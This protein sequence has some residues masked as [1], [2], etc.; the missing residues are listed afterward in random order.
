MHVLLF[1][2]LRFMVHYRYHRVETCVAYLW[3]HLKRPRGPF[4][5]A[6]KVKCFDVM[7]EHEEIRKKQAEVKSETT[8]FGM[9]Q[10]RL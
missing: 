7:W 2:S 10:L 1:S 5:F 4:L 8:M 3:A 9:V 6:S